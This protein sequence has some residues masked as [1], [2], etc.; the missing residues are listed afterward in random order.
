MVIISIQLKSGGITMCKSI[1]RSKPFEMFI[2]VIGIC[3]FIGFIYAIFFT[4]N[5]RADQRP[6]YQSSS[7]PYH[8]LQP[9]GAAQVGGYHI[10]KL[11]QQVIV[12]VER[13][14]TGEL[15]YRQALNYPYNYRVLIPID[16]QKKWYLYYDRQP[17]NTEFRPQ[18][19][20]KWFN[21]QSVDNP[22]NENQFYGQDSNKGRDFIV[23]PSN[24]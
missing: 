1:I 17:D 6:A 14:Y 13:A 3:I 8:H 19:E 15:M 5:V 7:G 23:Y 10:N 16:N 4:K 22:D 20:F 2:G 11:P 9:W 12:P 21:G 24:Q 18:Q